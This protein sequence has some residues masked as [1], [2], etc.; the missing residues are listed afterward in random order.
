MKIEK[1]NRKFKVG[2]NNIILTEA[3]KISLKQNEIVTFVN[4]K[5][6]YDI[7]KKGWG[8]YA[9]PSI[10]SR[11]LKFNLRTCIIKSTVTKN[12]FIVLVQKDKEK[13]FRKYLKNEKCKI[14]K[15]MS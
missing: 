3:A 12:S 8:F 9:T 15:W 5:T 6:E 13:K 14:V 11:L 10:N 7:V 2:I 4:G 1:K